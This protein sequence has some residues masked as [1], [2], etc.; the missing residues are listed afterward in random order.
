MV[1]APLCNSHGEAYL[2]TEMLRPIKG[3]S[4]RS[5]NRVLN[6]KGP[7]W[8][9]E[10]FDHA[11]RNDESAERKVEYICDNPVRKGLVTTEGEY[12]WLWRDWVEGAAE[13]GK[14]PS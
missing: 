1:F 2:L 14:R 5:V 6:R 4:A 13:M 10:S 8:Q 11:L 9:D 12:R 7:V 3:T